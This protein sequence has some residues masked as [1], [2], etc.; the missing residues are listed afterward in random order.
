MELSISER[1]ATARMDHVPRGVQTLLGMGRLPPTT[2]KL[3]NAL[4]LLQCVE[5]PS[6]KSAKNAI[7]VLRI[8]PR[9]GLLVLLHRLRVAL[10]QDVNAFYLQKFRDL[11]AVMV[12]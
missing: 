4:Y 7:V 5:T 10:H 1:N 6:V 2:V 3:A 12:K 8:A 9:L 11:I